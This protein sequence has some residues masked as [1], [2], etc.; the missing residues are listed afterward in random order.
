LRDAE[1]QKGR[2][3]LSLSLFGAPPKEDALHQLVELGFERLLFPL[4]PAP[5]ETV[6]PMIDDYAK[7]MAKMK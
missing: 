2:K 6:M 7:V 5:R 4:P 1:K 3:K